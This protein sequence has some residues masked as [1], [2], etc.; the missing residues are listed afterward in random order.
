MSDLGVVKYLRK[1]ATKLDLLPWTAKVQ[2]LVQSKLSQVAP[3]RAFLCFARVRW[4]N[5]PPEAIAKQVFD[6]GVER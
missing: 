4:R 2:T 5:R 6:Q 1:P 3:L